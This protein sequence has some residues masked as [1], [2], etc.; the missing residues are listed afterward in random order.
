MLLKSIKHD[1]ATHFLELAN[2]GQIILWKSM[3]TISKHYGHAL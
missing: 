3:L 2:D 1:L